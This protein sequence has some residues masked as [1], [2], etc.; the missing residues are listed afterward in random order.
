MEHLNSRLLWLGRL[1]LPE[2]AAV[3]L[4][5]W[6]KK[7]RL[8]WAEWGKEKLRKKKKDQSRPARFGRRSDSQFLNSL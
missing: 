5:V 2:R 3:G 7:S 6:K 4:G 1:A 8:G